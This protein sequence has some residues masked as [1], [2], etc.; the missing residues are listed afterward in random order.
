M[1]SLDAAKAFDS[2]E[3]RYLWAVLH[4]FRVEKSFI[5]W[6]QLLCGPQLR[7]RSNGVL[8]EAF[9]LQCETRQGCPLSPLLFALALE[10]LTA[11]VRSS[12]DIMGFHRGERVDKLSLYADDTLIYLRDTVGSPEAIMWLFDRFGQHSGFA[13]NWH[14]SSLYC[15]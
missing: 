6:I 5:A 9:P 8:S 13:I 7:L 12:P 10:P 14:K 15:L 1:F 2:V 11:M 4:K 3:W